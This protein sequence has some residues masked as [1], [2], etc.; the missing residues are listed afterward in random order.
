MPS[1]LQWIMMRVIPRRSGPPA[2]GL[3]PRAARSPAPIVIA[4]QVTPRAA[5]VSADEPVDL[6]PRAVR[7]GLL[8]RLE[9]LRDAAT[10]ENDRLLVDFLCRAVIDDK[11]DLP[12]FPAVCEELL[13]LEPTSNLDGNR[14]AGLISR[15]PD[16]VARIVQ[17]ASSA[18][19][20]GVRQTSLV[21]AVTRLG[22]EQVRHIAIGLSLSDAIAKAAGY[23]SEVTRLRD[24]GL[25]A[26]QLSSR[27]ARFV[28]RPMDGGIAFL[29]GLFHDV[30]QTLVLRNLSTVRARSRGGAASQ[31]LVRR[32]MADIH[33]SLGTL[34]GQHRNLPAPVVA[35][36][37]SHHEPARAPERH[38]W[39][40]HLIWAVD[41]MQE[42]EGSLD[43]PMTIAT[44]EQEWPDA[45]PPLKVT[46]E[47]ARNMGEATAI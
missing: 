28:G 9:R 34:Y 4:A 8:Q 10:L 2:S 46:L 43:D 16:L 26:G 32:L 15:D 19:F 27:I 5:S 37:A 24:K 44:L 11:L 21:Q 1:F 23:E 35:A 33:V 39:L 30:G 42:N 45:A 40:S 18:A 20:G 38:V 29:A 3:P 31:L 6:D 17:I 25:A 13:V 47:Q 36:I 14:V 41:R 12:R 7:L 22:F